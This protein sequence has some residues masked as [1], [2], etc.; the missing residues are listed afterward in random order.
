MAIMSYEERQKIQ[1]ALADEQLK[2][3]AQQRRQDDA[4]A[5]NTAQQTVDKQVQETT[6]TYRQ[7]QQE[8]T[9]TAWEELERNALEE[10]LG[11]QTVEQRMA[12]LGLANSGLAAS[13]QEAVTT[14]RDYR[15]RQ[16][17]RRLSDYVEKL[18]EAIAQA[19]A[20]GN[21][22]KAALQETSDANFHNWYASLEQKTYANADKTAAQLYNNDLKAQQAIEKAKAAA[23]KAQAAAKKQTAASK[24]NSSAKTSTNKNTTAK[25]Q[26]TA[27]PTTTTATPS[28]SGN[29]PTTPSSSVTRALDAVSNWDASSGGIF[30]KTFWSGPDGD[31]QNVYEDIVQEQLFASQPYKRL[32]TAEKNQA[33]AMAIGKSIAT[34]WPGKGDALKNI[35]RLRS[36]LLAAQKELKWDQQTLVKMQEKATEVYTGLT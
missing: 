26:P 35:T 34:T 32:S 5:L 4:I 24:T 33:I 25:T 20:E 29:A 7:K 17:T 21:A 36:A 1:R 23:A 27:K 15:D 28:P 12:N 13:S 8:A 19:Q 22:K 14:R 16:E 11:R 9:E 2:K 3:A 18:E 30:N 31:G 6:D 10:E